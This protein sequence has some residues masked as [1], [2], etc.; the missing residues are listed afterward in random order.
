MS[1]LPTY[2]YVASIR[3]LVISMIQ[4]RYLPYNFPAYVA[5]LKN[6]IINDFAN[7]FQK[8]SLY[9]NNFQNNL[10]QN[11]IM[12]FLVEIP[13]EGFFII[14]YIFF[15]EHC[16]PDLLKRVQRDLWV[17]CYHLPILRQMIE[18]DEYEGDYTNM[19]KI[20][21]QTNNEYIWNIIDKLPR[22]YIIDFLL[23]HHDLP[24]L[25]RFL[26][27]EEINEQLF[28]RAILFPTDKKVEYQQVAH[29]IG[30][31]VEFTKIGNYHFM[32]L[33][34]LTLEDI[35]TAGKIYSKYKFEL[36]RE[37]LGVM[38]KHGSK[39]G[40]RF[41]FNRIK[42][43]NKIVNI[44]FTANQACIRNQTEFVKWLIEYYPKYN[45]EISDLAVFKMIELRY[46][47]C[48][49]VVKN[50]I[51]KHHHD[52]ICQFGNDNFLRWYFNNF[53]IKERP[54]EFLAKNIWEEMRI[55]NT[56]NYYQKMF[57]TMWDQK[58]PIAEW[59]IKPQVI[60]FLVEKDRVP[61][62]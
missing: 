28:E 8:L 3:S 20:Q 45:I 19:F 47:D 31:Q 21:Y 33:V 26:T 57:K 46:F 51:R 59:M 16:T 50:S 38:G 11:I 60:G 52:K 58:L 34:S 56:R 17:F 7:S 37:D 30:K 55:E 18:N 9:T 22:E 27:K 32:F 1:F 35:H 54:T 24:N 48:L 23:F 53:D 40:F 25:Q 39:Q 12:D 42:Y 62:F 4:P 44:L 61:L 13:Y 2:C 10:F 29:W 43:S 36:T 41:V 5:T 6:D 49:K 14:L 15:K